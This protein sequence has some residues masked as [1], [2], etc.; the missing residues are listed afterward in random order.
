MYGEH[1]GIRQAANVLEMFRVYCVLRDVVSLVTVEGKAVD[2]LLRRRVWDLA[3]L[4][5]YICP[6]ITR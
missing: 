3:K 5:A 2:T 4:K 1:L 6:F